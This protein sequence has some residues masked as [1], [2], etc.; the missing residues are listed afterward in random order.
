MHQNEGVYASSRASVRTSVVKGGIKAEQHPLRDDHSAMPFLG[1]ICQL[2]E[3]TSMSFHVSRVGLCRGL[4]NCSCHYRSRYQTPKFLNQFLGTLF[5]GYTGLPYWD[6]TCDQ[7][8]CSSQ[9]SRTVTA[10][11]TF[12]QWF[13]SRTLNI[14][15]AMTHNGQPSLGIRVKNRVKIAESDIFTLA[16]LGDTQGI[17]EVFNR[18]RATIDDL[19]YHSGQTILQVAF[20]LGHIE[21]CKMLIDYGIDTFIMDDRQTSAAMEISKRILQHTDL[22]RGP[23]MERA[24]IGIAAAHSQIWEFSHVH[25]VVVGIS[26]ADLIQTL[27]DPIYSCQIDSLDCQG[28]TPL[29]WAALRGDE[30]TIKTLLLARAGANVVG[31][32]N[33]S[34][35][36]YAIESGS[37][38]CVELILMAGCSVHRQDIQGHAALHVAAWARDMPEMLETIYLAGAALELKDNTGC[39]ALECAANMNYAENVKFLLSTGA[40]IDCRDSDGSSPLFE[41]V[42]YSNYDAL[43]VLLDHKAKL[44][45]SDN[46][47]QTVL[48]LAAAHASTETVRLLGRVELAGLAGTEIDIMG[49]TFIDVFVER[50]NPPAGLAEAMNDIMQNL[51]VFQRKHSEDDHHDEGEKPFVDAEE[52]L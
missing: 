35:L 31:E 40:D 52:F 23:E 20:E 34:P 13:L 32:Q 3:S 10:A 39:T 37:I 49:R 16:R 12:P 19:V 48:H 33:R 36:H 43:Q 38:R 7:P 51:N 8:E 44:D 47:Q 30:V 9:F 14:V 46:L 6:K 42:R 4:C 5:I 15:A 50:V 24:F 41:A 29:H 22:R 2:G 27:H 1:S 17:I 25:K 11:Y 28:R 26:H 21:T 18:R 45:Y